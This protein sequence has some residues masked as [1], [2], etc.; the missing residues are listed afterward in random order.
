[1]QSASN[2]LVR[3]ATG[4]NVTWLPPTVRADWGEDGYGASGGWGVPNLVNDTFDDRATSGGWGAADA[5]T[6]HAQAWST[7]GGASNDYAVAGGYGTHQHSATNVAHHTLLGFDVPDTDIL[8]GVNLTT[9]ATGANLEAGVLTRYTSV[10]S[11]YEAQVERHPGSRVLDTFSRNVTAGWGNADTGHP[12][13]VLGTASEWNVVGGT[14]GRITLANPGDLHI[15]HLDIGDPDHECQAAF[16]IPVVPSSAPITVRVAGRF[17]DP[18]N[19]YEAQLMLA[20]G[21]GVRLVLFRW[22]NGVNVNVS[23]LTGVGAHTAGNTWNVALSCLGRTIRARAWKST[24]PRPG[25]QVSYAETS[26]TPP[27]GTRVGVLAIRESGNTNGTVNVDLPDFVA[28]GDPSLPESNVNVRLV[29]RS[30]STTVLA[31]ARLPFMATAGQTVWLRTQTSGA[32]IRVKAW[33]TDSAPRAVWDVQVRDA[34]SPLP[35]GRVGVRSLINTGFLASQLPNTIRFKQ[36]RMVNGGVDDLT[37]QVGDGYEVA[38]TID[39][40]LPDQVAF[41][42]GVGVPELSIGLADGRDGMSPAEYFSP[43]NAASPVC[44]FDRD[45][46]PVTLDQGLVTAAGPE[47]VRLFTGRM[48][49]LP[50]RGSSSLTG[51]SATR[52]KLAKAVQPPPVLAELE[53]GDATWLI[54]WTLHQCDVHVSPPVRVGCRFHATMHGAIRPA[55]PADQ[56][57]VYNVRPYDSANRPFN[58]E[59]IPGPFV[60]APNL[61]IDA[62]RKD[63]AVIQLGHLGDGDG[64]LIRTAYRGRFE[65]WIKGQATNAAAAPGGPGSALVSF[66]IQAFSDGG[67]GYAFMGIDNNRHPYVRL[68]GA[69]ADWTYTGAQTLPTDGGWYF[70][71]CAYDY[72][73][74]KAAVNLNGTVSASAAAAG[75][76]NINDLPIR[77]INPNGTSNQQFVHFSYLP[78]AE[79]QFTTGANA[80]P[81]TAPWLNQ[82]PWRVGAVVHPSANRFAALVETEATEAWELIGNRAKTEL[83][84]VH[85]DEQDILHYLPA[86]YWTQ[87]AQQVPTETISTDVNAGP[88]NISL[89]PSRIRNTVQVSYN[90][91]EVSTANVS[92]YQST[93]RLAVPRGSTSLDVTL[94]TTAVRLYAGYL[95]ILRPSQMDGTDPSPDNTSWITLNTAADGTGLELFYPKAYAQVHL[96]DANTARLTLTNN[97]SATVYAVNDG[98]VPYINI[99]GRAVTQTLATQTAVDDDSIAAR[100]ERSMTVNLPEIQRPGDAQQIAGALV[101]ELARAAPVVDDVTLFGDPRRQPGDLVIVDDPSQTKANGRYRLNSVVHRKVGAAFTQVV[102]ARRALP[103]GTWGNSTW[104][105]C[106]WT[107]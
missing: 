40:G 79:V 105:E 71:G 67:S 53:G 6:T 8:A 48:T 59:F 26:T 60:L 44:D 5:S 104:N 65:C 95:D 87:S 11:H 54:S 93:E 82:L 72:S 106:L 50:M 4:A 9:G 103:P 89:D 15:A 16:A 58:L 56:D 23:L 88:L 92:V 97:T 91:T 12:W 7:S 32:L 49:N 90:R 80:D 2:N 99:A 29:K 55:I 57:V 73:A 17:V 52:L 74:G 68:M 3:A 10:T 1:M 51:V 36:F 24:D 33:H 14:T 31:Q 43:F 66:S 45:V 98:S 64:A 70:L 34:G 96:I 30:G 21:G 94:A 35:T 84:S 75:V 81:N 46:A 101:A 76:F 83:A 19:Y 42:S 27:A 100:G 107:E 47:E 25:W 28:N 62:T 18:N 22:V 69:A 13:T 20:A 102:R 77:E 86:G 39:D 63:R 38:H 41:V 37:D 85:C 78:V 61:G